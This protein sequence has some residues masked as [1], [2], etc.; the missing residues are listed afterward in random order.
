MESVHRNNPTVG[1]F[2]FTAGSDFQQN[3]RVFF[4]GFPSAEQSAVFQINKCSL[5]GF[6]CNGIVRVCNQMIS[7][8]KTPFKIE[9]F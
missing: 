4:K 9:L 2:V 3:G 6:E 7:K 1:Q 8:Q 5:D